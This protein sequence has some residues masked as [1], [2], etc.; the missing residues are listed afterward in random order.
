[1]SNAPEPPRARDRGTLTLPSGCRNSAPKG[2]TRR[3]RTERDS[4]SFPSNSRDFS[5]KIAYC[6]ETYRRRFSHDSLANR[7]LEDA[8]AHGQSGP[9][10]MLPVTLQFIV[11]TIAYAINERMARR[12]DSGGSSGS[13]GGPYGGDRQDPDRFEHRAA[14]TPGTEG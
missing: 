1:M 10:P 8:A 3:N 13:E 11:A 14:A 6:P 12:V 9:D 5:A 7:R 2:G 4:N